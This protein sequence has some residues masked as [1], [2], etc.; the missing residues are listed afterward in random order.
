MVRAPGTR[1]VAREQV[2][3]GSERELKS[4]ELGDD[5]IRTIWRMRKQMTKL[6]RTDTDARADNWR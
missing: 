2:V 5:G 3:S 6:V 1:A 4:R